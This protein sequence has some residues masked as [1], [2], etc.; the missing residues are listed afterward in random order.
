VLK[1]I[2]HTY[3]YVVEIKICIIF[4]KELIL[5]IRLNIGLPKER[6]KERKNE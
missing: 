4:I 6:K 5:A 1:A 2:A 3:G